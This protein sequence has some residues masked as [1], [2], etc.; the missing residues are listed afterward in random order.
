[1][2]KPAFASLC[3]L[4]FGCGGQAFSATFP[5]AAD[6]ELSQVMGE[7]ASVAPRQ[8]TSVVVGI[9]GSPS[10]LFL[11]DLAAGRMVWT[12]AVQA[13]SAP[14]V[15]GSLVIT[16]EVAGVV[17]RH[18]DDGHVVFALE[19]DVR[20]IGADGHGERVLI[21]VAFGPESSQHGRVIMVESGSVR[22]S[23]EMQLP[24]GAPALVGNNAVVP[25]ATQRISILDA[26]TGRERTRL[27]V[28]DD[29]VAHAFVHE[30]S[31]YVG[32]HG[33]FRITPSLV[34]GTKSDAAYFLPR[35]RPL[36]AQPPLMRDGY[37][38]YPS[39]DNAYHRVRLHW[40]PAGEGE[41]VS[42][43]ADTL[44]Y[45]FYRMLFAFDA[46]TDAVRWVYTHPVDAVGAAVV[47]AGVLLIGQRGKGVLVDA[48]GHGHELFD[49]GRPVQAAT[50]RT[51]AWSPPEPTPAD[52][53]SLAEQLQAAASLPDDRLAAG[54]ALAVRYLARFEEPEVTARLIA[55]CADRDGAEP[56]RI[57][58]C[59]AVS[60]RTSGPE[61]VRAALSEEPSFLEAKPA[62]P[63]GV[64]AEAAGRM[65]LRVLVPVLLRHLS[66]PATP[67]EELPGLFRGLARLGQRAAVGPAE[68]FLR[69][70][71]C[72]TDGVLIE[73]VV[74]A[75]EMLA[76][77]EGRAAVPTLQEAANDPLAPPA[78]RTR[79]QAAIA[80]I[81]RAEAEAAA[82]AARPAEEAPTD[83]QPAPVDT[84]PARLNA[85]HTRATL[86][87]V[88]ERLR[89]CLPEGASS[90]RVVLMIRPDGAIAT[91]AVNPA[92]AQECMEPVVRGRSFPAT[93]FEGG[94]QQATYRVMR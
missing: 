83:E 33:L 23:E 59:Q 3:A 55:L 60:Q 82:E 65:N 16:Q 92:T 49:M 45:Q 36:P 62:P 54:R 42:L 79:V 38:A 1:V 56:V 18:V 19:D 12:Q 73:A 89:A 87:P 57:E 26:A 58:A 40:R 30:G 10:E 8:E 61:H 51:G 37:S 88:L 31:V 43:A 24:V 46:N 35:A 80:S 91:V 21:A 48:S 25:W 53:R 11:W 72:E 9:G 27:R 50:V 71:H 67:N 41:T 84:R 81:E 69:L 32:Q 14:I 34:A 90:A 22:W 68:K 85:N 15:A 63:V 64:L 52:A 70:Y 66:D 39:P 77:I 2:T 17:A 94:S 6:P 28:R 78:V 4:A 44:Y 47:G 93:R 20:L 7:L 86:D 74:A 76:L 29:V 13:R 75:A 5:E